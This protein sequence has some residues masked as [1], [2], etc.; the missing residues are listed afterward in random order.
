MARIKKQKEEETRRYEGRLKALKMEYEA[1]KLASDRLPPAQEL[2]DT[3]SIK[4]KIQSATAIN[5]KAFEYNRYIQAL[6][7]KK[8]FEDCLSRNKAEQEK[9]ISERTEY[10]QSKTFG[11]KGLQIDEDGNLTKDG[12]LIR[13][14]YFSKGELEVLVA[15]IAMN[16]NPEL[17]VRFIDNFEVLDDKNQ[18]LLINNLTKKGFQIITAQVG[19]KA[20]GDNSVLLRDCRLDVLPGTKAESVNSGNGGAVDQFDHVGQVE[21]DEDYY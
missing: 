11:I 6:D 5:E 4:K 3:G 18:L 1:T 14:P 12:K 21:Q 2:I 17:K 19:S 9:I 13:Q 15:R 10:L 20:I 16:L 7:S 8:G